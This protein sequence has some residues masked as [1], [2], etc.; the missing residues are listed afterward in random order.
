LAKKFEAKFFES[1]L[2]FVFSTLKFG[3]SKI[4]VSISHNIP[5]W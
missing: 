2:Q 4:S 3:L 5:V 1:I